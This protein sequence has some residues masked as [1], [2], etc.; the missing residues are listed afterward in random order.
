MQND[1]N[2]YEIVICDSLTGDGPECMEENLVTQKEPVVEDNKI[3]L[4]GDKGSVTVAVSE[5]DVQIRVIR[6]IFRNHLGK[7][8]DVWLIR[9]V[10]PL[11]DK[12]ACCRILCSY[13]PGV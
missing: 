13:A 10:V 4:K 5:V 1:T 8:E 11:K 9:F 7:N 3:I 2:S 12:K 6:E